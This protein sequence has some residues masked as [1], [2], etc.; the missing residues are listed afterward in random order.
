MSRPRRQTTKGRLQAEVAAEKELDEREEQLARQ[1]AQVRAELVLERMSEQPLTDACVRA[2]FRWLQRAT[3]RAL[4]DGG[5]RGGP[6]RRRVTSASPEG[7][8]S[9]ARAASGA[10][11]GSGHVVVHG[12]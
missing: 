1:L 10:V 5:S 4:V 6:L 11:K 7:S 3:A 9:P 2:P 12:G 8:R